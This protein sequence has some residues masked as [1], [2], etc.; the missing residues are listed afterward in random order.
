METSE[1]PFR[2][3]TGLTCPLDIYQVLTWILVSLS[4]TDFIVVNWTFLSPRDSAFWGV[5]YLSC[6]SI[7][8]FLFAIA[9]F[10]EHQLPPSYSPD[11]V[12]H[13]RY[14]N[15]DTPIAAKHCR[16]CNRCRLGFDHHCRFINNCVTASN[17][18][19]F[20]YGCMFLL[21][22]WYLAIAHLIR[23]MIAFPGTREEVLG[24]LTERFGMETSELAYWILAVFGLVINL[25]IGGPMTALVAYHTYFQR[26]CVSTYDFLKKRFPNAAQNLQPFCCSCSPRVRVGV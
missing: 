2:R 4:L 14:C 11:H 1:R 26:I 24:R 8:I 25:G 13:C 23:S 18:V 12:S 15:E 7:G 17:Y 5:L 6:W 16:V 3:K 21:S 22:A 20:F 9:T 19:A 10:T